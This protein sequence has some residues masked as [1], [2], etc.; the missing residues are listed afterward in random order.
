MLLV[1]QEVA[2]NA[3][4]SWI[5][6]A[7]R[8]VEL[9]V[10]GRRLSVLFMDADLLGRLAHNICVKVARLLMLRVFSGTELYAH[11]TTIA[12]VVPIG[13]VKCNKCRR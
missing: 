2:L 1:G 5:K 9:Y 7:E 3:V 12:E 8:R 11:T 10:L 6:Q 4:Q 13:Q